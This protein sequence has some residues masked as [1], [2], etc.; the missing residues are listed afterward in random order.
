MNWKAKVDAMKSMR[1]IFL[2]LAL[3]LPVSVLVSN[4][5]LAKTKL[6]AT[7]FSYDGNDMFGPK[8]L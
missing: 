2:I 5:S 1:R 4:A 6:E 7:I 3:L 8:R